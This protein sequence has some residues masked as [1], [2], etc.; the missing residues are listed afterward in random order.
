MRKIVTYKRGVEC[1]LSRNLNRLA[2]IEFNSFIDSAY[3]Q[4]N[5]YGDVVTEI[6]LKSDF[7]GIYHISVQ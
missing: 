4:E 3:S 5:I 6:P 2:S 7:N 1:G